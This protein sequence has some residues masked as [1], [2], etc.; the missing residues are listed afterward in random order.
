MLGGQHYIG[1]A[2][3]TTQL[4]VQDVER[5]AKAGVSMS[6]GPVHVLPDP[7][8]TPGPAR[9]PL[10]D[11]IRDR[12]IQ[13]KKATRTSSNFDEAFM[14]PE[15]YATQHEGQVY[16]FV[17]AGNSPPEVIIDD[18]AIYPSDALLA[19]IVLLESLGK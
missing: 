7:I 10:A 8:V 12:Y 19:R 14:V 1:E 4:C 13:S 11:A 16:V 18:A 6:I 17:Y 3:V 5:L 9:N 2:L 15:V